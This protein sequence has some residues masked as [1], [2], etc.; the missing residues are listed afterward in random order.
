MRC[1][2]VM[3]TTNNGANPEP[4]ASLV[5]L[6]YSLPQG[7]APQVTSRT[8]QRRLR[9]HSV[10]PGA[11]Q[12]GQS[13]AVAMGEKTGLAHLRRTSQR[14]GEPNASAVVNFGTSTAQFGAV[15]ASTPRIW[16][17]SSTTTT[18]FTGASHPI[19][20]HI[21]SRIEIKFYHSEPR[22]KFYC[23]LVTVQ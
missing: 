11:N 1:I 6:G 23:P 3:V 7:A 19:P 15:H 21:F 8:L 9:L 13:V 10:V 16:S 20:F 17:S 18:T 12:R 5:S 2:T 22:Q 14:R 4:Y